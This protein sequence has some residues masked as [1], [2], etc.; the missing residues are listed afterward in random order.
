MK[1]GFVDYYLDEWHANNYP[2]WIREASGGT[3]EVSLAFGL[4]LTG[5]GLVFSILFIFLHR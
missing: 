2:Q 5:L 4:I 3:M 1:I